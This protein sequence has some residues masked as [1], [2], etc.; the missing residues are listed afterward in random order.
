[1]Q[2]LSERRWEWRIGRGRRIARERR[3]TPEPGPSTA[4]EDML[5]DASRS[6]ARYD[7]VTDWSDGRSTLAEKLMVSSWALR[8]WRSGSQFRGRMLRSTALTVVV[9]AAAVA[10][11]ALF[12]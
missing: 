6:T 9:A 7:A 3:T 12:A 1:M 8:Y 2:R 10:L 11:A 5:D 4:V